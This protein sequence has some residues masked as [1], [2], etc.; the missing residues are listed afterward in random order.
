MSNKFELLEGI[1]N[2][3]NNFISFANLSKVTILNEKKESKLALINQPLGHYK[4]LIMKSI[5]IIKK[6]EFGKRG[7]D[8][9]EWRTY[10][11]CERS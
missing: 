5:D 9:R 2:N 11:R 1:D 10:Y 7:S 6:E 8:R 4:Q 3:I